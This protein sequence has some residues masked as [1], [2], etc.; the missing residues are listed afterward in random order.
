MKEIELRLALVFYGGVSLAI[1]MHGVSREVLHLVRASACRSERIGRNGVYP[2]KDR[3]PSKS[4]RAYEAL[5]DRLGRNVDIRVVADAIAGA[6]AGGVNGIMLARAIAHDL[7]LDGHRDLWLKHA[8]VTELA[9]PQDGI[10][11]YLKS[12][13][14]PVVDSLISQRLKKDISDPETREKLRTLMQSRWFSPPFSGERYIGWM[15]D[16]C[17]EMEKGHRH[18]STLIPRGQSLDLFVTL[19]DYR[20]QLRCIRIDDPAYVEEWDHRRLLKF[21]ARHRSPSLLQSDFD[22]ASVPELVFAARATSSFPGAFPPATIGEMD[23]VL[24]SRG[25]SWSNREAFLAGQLGLDS[26]GAQRRSFVDGSVVMNKPFSPVIETIR[27][28]AAARE[29]ERRLI[30]VDPVPSTYAGDLPGDSAPGF[31]KVVLASLAHIPRNEP[32]GDD[33]RE[34]EA[35]NRR[36][37]WLAQTITAADPVV[38]LAVSKIL[39]RRGV[40]KAGKLTQ[41][42]QRANTAAHQ[43]AGFAFLN[44]QSLKLHAVGEQLARLLAGLSKP[45]VSE[46]RTDALMTMISAYLH[47]LAG[48]LENGPPKVDDGIVR[49]LRSLDVDYRI[50]RLRF[51]I[52]KLN[53][54][55]P[56]AALGEDNAD[57][58]ALDRLKGLLYEQIDHLSQRWE[59]DFYG[60]YSRQ[61]AL[62]LAALEVGIGGGTN[63]EIINICVSQIGEMM[64]LGDL[65]R[66]QDEIFAETAAELLPHSFYKELMHSY[67]GFAFYDLVIFPVLQSNDFSEISETLI[68]RISPKDTVLLREEGF[69]LKGAALNNFGAFFNRSWR[70]H[71]YLWGRLNA[72]ERLVR[73][74]VSAAKDPALPEKELFELQQGLFRAILEEEQD[75]LQAD[76]QLVPGLMRRVKD[77][78]R[79]DGVGGKTVPAA[80]SPGGSKQS[81]AM[82]VERK[83]PMNEALVAGE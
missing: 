77:L 65:D 64:G 5:L 83:Q 72:A 50:R 20:G 74:L 38:E 55:Y 76:P 12:S 27:G 73:I 30:Y 70:E 81:T 44:Y 15:L 67:V 79:P 60:A 2:S 48:Q 14:S 53:S 45:D 57:P 41:Y 24:K 34:I 61:M 49:F 22:S 68:D 4:E 39:P 40:L 16:A 82:A 29:V 6:S 25:E 66:L 46:T 1:Y 42:R 37:R 71:D 33:L 54:L 43:Q 7:P 18:G 8:D 26:E 62:H 78:V 19:T 51:A 52:R 23:R 3:E 32:I 58:D 47:N 56:R 35:H 59:T 36:G 31:F 75:K 10:R 80:E 28:R 21:Q 9:R 69:T 13:I 11:R 17:Q 63:R